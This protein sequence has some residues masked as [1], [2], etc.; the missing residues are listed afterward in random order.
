MRYPLPS[1]ET[2][3]LTADVRQLNQLVRR[4]AVTRLRAAGFIQATYAWYHPDHWQWAPWACE[5]AYTGE[6]KQAHEERYSVRGRYVIREEAYRPLTK[7]AQCWMKE[8]GE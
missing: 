7:A 5:G 8:Q 1:A 2:L 4:S 3:V 6:R